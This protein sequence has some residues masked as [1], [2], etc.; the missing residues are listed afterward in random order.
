MPLKPAP[1]N[2]AFFAISI[3]GFLTSTFYIYHYS[4]QWGIAFAL[5]FALMFI[6]SLL[7]MRQ[8][9]IGKPVHPHHFKKYR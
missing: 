4:Q 6:A 8:M 7:S 9:G 2:S 1:L 3:L 5:V